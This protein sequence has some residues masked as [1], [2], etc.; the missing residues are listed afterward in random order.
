MTDPTNLSAALA[1]CRDARRS[2][3]DVLERELAQ[4]AGSSEASFRDRLWNSLDTQSG[5]HAEGW[6]DPPP[7]GIGVLFAAPPDYS[8]LSFDSLRRE[9]Y[10]P[11]FE[12]AFS[13]ESVCIFYVSPVHVSGGIIGDVGRSPQIREHVAHVY[14]VVREAAQGADVGMPFCELHRNAQALFRKHGLHNERTVTD[15]DPLG[16]N[17]GHTIPFSYEADAADV[18]DRADLARLREAI[19]TRRKYVN[20]IEQFRIPETVAFTLEAR[21]ES[22]AD[23][24]LPNVFFH[25]VLIFENGRRTI[26]AGYERMCGISPP[27]G[28]RPS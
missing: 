18:P 5:L 6:Y 17:L 25:V 3:L 27:H 26:E 24:A 28:T 8:R 12:R 11:K 16:T 9:N 14:A 13:E 23:P 7:H 21:L 2:A 10:W 15:T 22:R 1:A 4:I 19:R 20:R